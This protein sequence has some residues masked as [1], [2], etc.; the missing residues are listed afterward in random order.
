MKNLKNITLEISLK[1]FDCDENHIESICRKIFEDWRPLLK[2]SDSV[3]IM[4]WCADGSEI[5]DYKGELSDTFEW[6]YF[7]S[8]ANSP[9]EF[10]S[11]W[12]G[13]KYR[14]DPGIMTYG[15]LRFIT[16]TL[17]QTGKDLF[18][19]KEIS[20][21]ETFDIGPEFAISDF[22]YRRHREVLG[23]HGEG[24][25]TMFIDSTAT[26]AKDTCKYA[27][28]PDGIPEGTRF[29]TFLGK[30]ANIFLSDIG[31]DGLWL[32]N[33]MGFSVEPWQTEGKVFSL[34]SFHSEKI[35]KTKS[36]VAEFWRLLRCEM[37]DAEILT[38]GTNLSLGIDYS[39]D[40]VPLY[41]LYKSSLNFLPPCNSPWAAL[42]G[43]YGLEIMGHMSRNAVV[44][45]DDDWLFRFYIHDPWFK[46]SPW[47][48]RYEG[49]PSDI[50]LPM[51]LSR[52]DEKGNTS[53]ANHLHIFSID[54]SYGT[55]PDP[56][57][58][59]PLPHLLRALRESP[60]APSPIVWLYPAREYCQVTD[61]Y[62]LREMFGSDWLICDA[63]NHT[64]PL[65]SV[66]STD[67][68]I[69]IDLSVLN[70][71]IILSPVPYAASEWEKRLLEY[72][73]SGGKA[74]IVGS[75]TYAGEK[76][77]SMLGIKTNNS[78]SLSAALPSNAIMDTAKHGEYSRLLMQD[79]VAGVECFNCE[80]NENSD[81]NCMISK[82]GVLL[83]KGKNNVFWTCGA[84]TGIY[85]KGSS[86][87][88]VSGE[89]ERANGGS[90]MR[91]AAKY[92]GWDI[93]IKHH[94]LFCPEPSIMP[95][96]MMIHRHDNGFFFSTVTRN[97]TAEIYLSS[98]YGAP[99]MMGYETVYK[100]KK[101]SYRF[102][103]AEHL[104]CRVFLEENED[105]MLVSARE[106]LPCHA[107][108]R[109]SRRT[110]EVRWLKNATVRIFPEKYALDTLFARVYTDGDALALDSRRGDFI[111]RR[112][113][114]SY[115]AENITGILEIYFPDYDNWREHYKNISESL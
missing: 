12:G 15:K 5:L 64:F 23:G 22:K 96:K 18:P 78:Q 47:Y 29:A 9:A 111:W 19:D 6:C 25:R 32:S 4:L 7:I 36:E 45:D 109:S 75:L 16:D 86:H 40:A 73:G 80:N 87:L 77:K 11:E 41:E 60:D 101:V 67:S 63:I 70:E 107:L 66:I 46:N 56:C 1:P 49:R 31:F 38:R 105:D 83:A 59:E 13:K 72:I 28:Y 61:E 97:T 62:R 85:K 103:R 52:I 20:I 51:A 3:S 98:P 110:V 50:Y 81:E 34:G 58:V 71:S 93:S 27:A 113:G 94:S 55:M 10:G 91:N 14:D 21:I 17:R 24:I 39:T 115:V 106:A 30:Q 54:N 48:D 102:P 90:F 33:G 95:P 114:N 104:E 100:N 8:T 65:S 68:F 99:L 44:P 35:S 37:P 53:C 84:Q 79:S 74:I 112:D 42:D 43:N 88:V 76:L 69:N 2:H 108:S 26:L 92:F 82:D 89:D 57:V